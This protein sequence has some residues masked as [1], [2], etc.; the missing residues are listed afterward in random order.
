MIKI[1]QECLPIGWVTRSYFLFVSA[2]QDKQPSL[3]IIASLLVLTMTSFLLIE[4]LMI[5][6]GT[7][8]PLNRLRIIF[9]F[10]AGIALFVFGIG[11]AI[12]ASG[13]YAANTHDMD[14]HSRIRLADDLRTPKLC[15]L[16]RRGYR[17]CDCFRGHGGLHCR[18]IGSES[19]E[20]HY[21]NTAM[22]ARLI[23]SCLHF[24]C[25]SISIRLMYLSMFALLLLLLSRNTPIGLDGILLFYYD[26]Y[27]FERTN[28]HHEDSPQQ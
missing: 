13:R 23:Q 14:Y 4:Q 10:G 25:I 11:A 3:M 5:T 21:L 26:Y 12:I 7:V 17:H 9:A 22:K 2:Q 27:Y 15:S 28:V 20:S 18:R 16:F 19:Q 1:G 6:D 24:P 8:A